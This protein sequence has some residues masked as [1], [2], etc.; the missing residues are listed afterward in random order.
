MPQWIIEVPSYFS[1]VLHQDLSTFRNLT[2][3]QYPP[4]VLSFQRGAHKRFHLF[5]A[6][7]SWK[8]T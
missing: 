2:L 8:R 3:L 5:T 7:I 4:A 6:T 1:Q